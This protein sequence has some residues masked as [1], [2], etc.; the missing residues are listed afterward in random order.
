[1]SLAYCA[2]TGVTGCFGYRAS[3]RHQNDQEPLQKP[4]AGKIAKLGKTIRLYA[5]KNAKREVVDSDFGVFVSDALA[6]PIF[7]KWAAVK[8][9]R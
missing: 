8:G 3:G 6:Y 4:V 2:S 7:Q 5:P 9:G 1:M